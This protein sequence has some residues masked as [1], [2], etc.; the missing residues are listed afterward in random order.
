MERERESHI[1]NI[2]WPD[3]YKGERFLHKN[4]SLVFVLCNL[5]RPFIHALIY[6]RVGEENMLW[7]CCFV[8]A[9]PQLPVFLFFFFFSFSSSHLISSLFFFSF[10]LLV[11]FT[12]DT[13]TITKYLSSILCFHQLPFLN[14]SMNG[15]L[16][17]MSINRLL[18]PYTYCISTPLTSV[19]YDISTCLIIC[20]II[21]PY[22]F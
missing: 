19:D 11:L 9:Y 21:F 5:F 1:H 7:C 4:F 22:S 15:K 12:S 6:G 13:Y 18:L 14:L 2:D 17:E 3:G 10:L 16:W 8:W 20:A